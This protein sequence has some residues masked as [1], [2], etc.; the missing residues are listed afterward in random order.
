MSADTPS[1]GPASGVLAVVEVVGD[2]AG[3]D[4][5]VVD[6]EDAQSVAVIAVIAVVAVAVVVRASPQDG[7]HSQRCRVV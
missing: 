3:S 4:V 2:G 6:E 5:D 7:D 1:V